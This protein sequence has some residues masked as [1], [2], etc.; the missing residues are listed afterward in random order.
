M[1]EEPVYLLKNAHKPGQ[2]EQF[3]RELYDALSVL[4]SSDYTVWANVSGASISLA[5][6]PSEIDDEVSSFQT[7]EA[8]SIDNLTFQAGRCI[9]VRIA[10]ISHPVVQELVNGAGYNIRPEPP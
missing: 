3:L 5:R 10:D 4:N 8:G 1:P 7:V 9:L 6:S 2:P